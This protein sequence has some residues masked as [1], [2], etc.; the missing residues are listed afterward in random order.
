MKKRTKGYNT[1]ILTGI[2][3]LFFFSA[4]KLTLGIHSD[5][6]YLIAIGDMIARGA[7]FF[8]E[9]W[10][11]LQMSAVISA[12]FIWIYEQI[13]GGT[14]GIL[15]FLRLI[16]LIIQSGI[17]VY[18]YFVFRRRYNKYYVL[19]ASLMFFMYIPDAQS[20][21]YNPNTLFYKSPQTFN[22]Y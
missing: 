13:C 16:S 3:I 20:F 11:S 2:A 10:S 6:V 17:A 5:E 9:C 15:L 4:W 21:N 19:V 7:S 14:E 18:F 22:Q 8:K 12:P 1:I